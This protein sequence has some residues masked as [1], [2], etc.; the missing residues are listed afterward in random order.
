MYEKQG[1]TFRAHT[2]IGPHQIGRLAKDIGNSVR[3][4]LPGFPFIRFEGARPGRLMFSIRSW[5]G[6]VELISLCIDIRSDRNGLT[7]VNTHIEGMKPT[8]HKVRLIPM[9]AKQFVGYGIYKKYAQSLGEA[10]QRFD[11]HRVGILVEK[12]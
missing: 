4:G 2:Y 1:T 5:G 7:S 9:Q 8:R 6:H 11:P 3:G 10:L 12:L